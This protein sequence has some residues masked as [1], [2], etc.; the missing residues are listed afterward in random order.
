M[1]CRSL[2]LH[3]YTCIT[4][5]SVSQARK[6]IFMMLCGTQQIGRERGEREGWVVHICMEQSVDLHVH[7]NYEGDL[8]LGPG[9]A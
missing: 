9:I 7:N 3:L 2:H 1:Q 8:E 5:A 6:E 4:V